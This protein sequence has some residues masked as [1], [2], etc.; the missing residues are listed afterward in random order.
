MKVIRLSQSRTDATQER[1]VLFTCIFLIFFFV[2]AFALA[3]EQLQQGGVRSGSPATGRRL[4]QG[5]LAVQRCHPA[6]VRQM[7]GQD[8]PA[9]GQ[10]VNQST[11]FRKKKRRWNFVS[12]KKWMI[13]FCSDS[14]SFPPRSSQV[15]VPWPV[16]HGDGGCQVCDIIV[17]VCWRIACDH[18]LHDLFL[19]YF[20][21]DIRAY[22]KAAI[23]CCGKEAVTN[24]DTQA[25]E[26]ELNLQ[27][28]LSPCLYYKTLWFS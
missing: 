16:W 18:H 14:V 24:F 4:R 6:Q 17:A 9:H 10:E 22:D 8:R 3:D 19:I 12:F 23:K 26:D 15:R 21:Y 7:G 25:Y 2:M 13:Q 27:C 11:H 1:T 28:N 5:E 20:Y